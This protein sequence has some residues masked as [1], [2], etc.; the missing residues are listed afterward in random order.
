MTF[1]R[2]SIHARRTLLSTLLF[3]SIPVVAHSTNP[4][5]FA[6]RLVERG[7]RVFWYAGHAFHEAIAAAGAVPLPYVSA[8]DFSGQEIAEAFPEVAQLSGVAGI[9]RAFADI[10]V[11][12]APGRVADLQ[13][14]L[15]AHRVDA[16]LADGLM[17]GV[18]LVHELGGPPWASFGDGPL[19]YEEWDTPPFGPALPYRRDAFGAL[20]NGVVRPA[21]RLAIFGPA[22]RRYRQIRRS[23][24]LP[25]ATGP[26]ISQTTSPYLHLQGC[27]PGFEYPRQHRPAHLH[28]VGALRP[29]LPREWTPPL[30]WPEV[31]ASRRPV[32]LVSQGSL[33]P[34]LTELLVPAV[35]A[36]A[37]QDVLVVVTTGASSVNQLEQA[38]GGTLP[39]NVRAARF[40]PYD[41]AL[42]YV[43]AF[44]TNGGY[45]GGDP[46]PAPRR[47]AGPGRGHR[48]EG[49]DCRPDR[50]GRGGRTAGHH[51]TQCR[52]GRRRRSSGARLP[53]LPSRGRPGASGD[54]G[55][56]RRSRGCGSVGAAGQHQSSRPS[57]VA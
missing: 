34:D 41:V 57:G 8:P 40:V 25:R 39:A 6:T 44:V 52:G 20:R 5:P 1:G 32:V 46:R 47:A 56:R 10:F 55:T 48:G 29:V 33:R 30:W 9:R 16:V 23:L 12:H 3:A 38:M 37:G 36:L 45:T 26:V 27:T 42:P 49:R 17:Y 14:I 31:T 4:L 21:S 54:G 24:G 35:T 7:H 2:G 22:E 19:P 18:G 50:L 13:H 43:A 28:W 11:G 15:A 53:V 51:P